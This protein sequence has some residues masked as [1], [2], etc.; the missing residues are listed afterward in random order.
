MSED[1]Q[2]NRKYAEIKFDSRYFLI[3]AR[4]LLQIWPVLQV[5]KI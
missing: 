5:S 4:V 2:I 1:C 3:R